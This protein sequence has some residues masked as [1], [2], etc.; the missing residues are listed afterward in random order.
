M[1][2]LSSE[3]LYIGKENAPWNIE[4]NI[5]V[6]GG[7]VRMLELLDSLARAPTSHCCIKSVWLISH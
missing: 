3:K 2:G 5:S 1:C 4:I 7:V 6:P